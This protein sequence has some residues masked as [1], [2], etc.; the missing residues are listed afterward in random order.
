MNQMTSQ[1]TQNKIHAFVVAGIVIF[2]SFESLFFHD[3]IFENRNN[4]E[5]YTNDFVSYWMILE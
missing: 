5:I 2:D 4:G 3:W 1:N